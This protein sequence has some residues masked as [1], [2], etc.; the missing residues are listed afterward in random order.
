GLGP[1]ADSFD[2]SLCAC[3]TPGTCARPPTYGTMSRT[4]GLGTSVIICVPV[5]ARRYR[6]GRETIKAQG[7]I[8]ALDESGRALE[9]GAK[10]KTWTTGRTRR[11][12][13]LSNCWDRYSGPHA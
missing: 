13:V 9:R 10:P 2:E 7:C 1:R 8:V 4:P 5:G 6:M 11:R 12:L 3:S